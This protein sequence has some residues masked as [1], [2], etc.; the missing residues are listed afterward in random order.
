MERNIQEL[1]SN[2]RFLQEDCAN[3]EA[4]EFDDKNWDTLLE[5][6][7]ID[8]YDKVYRKSST[9]PI[10]EVSNEVTTDAVTEILQIYSNLDKQ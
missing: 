3:A 5:K 4:V 1:K 7:L 9:P 6:V 2:W 8:Y 10:A